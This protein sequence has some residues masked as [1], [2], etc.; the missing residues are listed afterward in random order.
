MKFEG[1][2]FFEL[3]PTITNDYGPNCQIKVYN[4]LQLQY[5]KDTQKGEG[6]M[7]NYAEAHLMLQIPKLVKIR[8]Q[9]KKVSQA[10]RRL[11]QPEPGG[12]AGPSL[13]GTI[14]MNTP[15]S[16]TVFSD[17][18]GK[19]VSSKFGD[20]LES[21]RSH[22][23]HNMPGNVESKYTVKEPEHQEWSL[24]VRFIVKQSN[25]QVGKDFKKPEKLDIYVSQN[26]LEPSPSDD[27]FLSKGIYH[28]A[29]NFN[30]KEKANYDKEFGNSEVY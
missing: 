13:D 11:E 10:I 2:H 15:E 1:S 6:E 5:V 16:S 8:E 19:S 9:K 18:D 4:Q 23:A 25:V 29:M 20:T 24:P 14:G 17:S 22:E 12:T 7:K 28:S 3:E 27:G 30:V 26:T 21:C